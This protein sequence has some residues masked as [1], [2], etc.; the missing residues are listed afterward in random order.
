M[1]RDLHLAY[2]ALFWGGLIYLLSRPKTG[3][4]HAVVGAGYFAF[5]WT[6]SRLFQEV[7]G[8]PGLR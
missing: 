3:P 8:P 4:I 1:T 6:G 7:R 2:L 5:G